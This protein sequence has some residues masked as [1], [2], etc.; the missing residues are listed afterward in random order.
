MET[1]TDGD[2]AREEGGGESVGA[3]VGAG[4]DIHDLVESGFAQVHGHAI[5][6]AD[7]HERIIFLNVAVLFGVAILH[8]RLHKGALATG[9]R[10]QDHA[11]EAPDTN[12]S[13]ISYSAISEKAD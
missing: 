13:M 9:A 2:S 6:T 7:A 5:F 10:H 12:Y 8:Q 3:H 4:D 1:R 11:L